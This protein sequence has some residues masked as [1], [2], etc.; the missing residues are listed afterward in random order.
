MEFHSCCPGRSAM[1]RSQL[2]A[3]FTSRVQCW[4]CRHEPLCLAHLFFAVQVPISLIFKVSQRR[5]G[6]RWAVHSQWKGE[7]YATALE[8]RQHPLPGIFCVQLRIRHRSSLSPVPPSRTAEPPTKYQ[9]SQPEVYVAA[10]G[11]SLEVRCL[12][13]DA[14]VISWTKDGVHLGPNNRT[15]LIG[16]YLQIK[17]ATPRDSGLYACTTTRTV[18]SETWYFMVNV[19]DAISSGDDEDD[20]DGVEDFVSESS[21]SKSK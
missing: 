6:T 17:G 13:K 5:R 20:T 8:K 15:V 10:P 4:N 18:D 11:D 14:T 2:I 12:L 7:K 9:I 19:T 1:A 16:E 3:T 21:N